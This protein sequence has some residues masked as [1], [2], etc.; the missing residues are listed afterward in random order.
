MPIGCLKLGGF[1][2]VVWSGVRLLLVWFGTE[3]LNGTSRISW[4]FVSMWD[5]GVDAKAAHHRAGLIPP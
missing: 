1:D 4:M 3:V 5:L 2:W